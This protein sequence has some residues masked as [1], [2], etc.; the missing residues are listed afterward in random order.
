[1]NSNKG[2]DVLTKGLEQ[3]NA[4]KDV[5]TTHT[6]SKFVETRTKPGLN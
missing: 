6:R 4:F 1:M 3:G 2:Y 5:R